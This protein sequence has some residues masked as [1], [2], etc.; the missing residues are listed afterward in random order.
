VITNKFNVELHRTFNYFEEA[1]MKTS[2]RT[3]ILLTF[4]LPLF[5]GCMVY[6][7]AAEFIKQR[8]TNTVA[9]FNTFYN[10]QRAFSDAEDEL[11]KAKKDYDE[12]PNQ[13]KPF[14]ISQ[15]T[16]VKFNASIEKNSKILTFYA[17]SKW[18]DDA[19]FMIGKSYSY[20]EEYAKAERKYLELFAKY[21]EST[22]IPEV[23]LWYGE[24]LLQQKKFDQGT[25]QLEE[26][27]DEKKYDDDIVGKA[28]KDLADYYYTQENYDGALKYDDIALRYISDNEL[29]ASIDYQRG[30][31][32]E[33]MQKYSDAE[34]AF[35]EA[36]DH[37]PGYAMIFRSTMRR[38]GTIEKQKKY[39]DAL[40]IL[41]DLKEDG[42]NAE[43]FGTIHFEIANVLYLK[44]DRTGA[45]DEYNYIDTAYVRTDES[46]KSL[47]RLAQIY[48][49]EYLNYDSAR[50][51]YN[52][53]KIEYPN[54]EITKDALVKANV[55]NK[56]DQL[57]KDLLKYDSLYHKAVIDL[58]SADTMDAWTAMQQSRHPQQEQPSAAVQKQKKIS[59]DSSFIK[60]SRL[61]QKDE[62]SK[63][64]VAAIDST[65]IKIALST[66]TMQKTMIDSMQRTMM[67][68]KF[69]L[70]GLFY[71]ELQQPDSAL[72]WFNDVI[73]YYPK[74][75]LIAQALYTIADIKGTLKTSSNTELDSI[76]TLIINEY[77]KSPYAQESRRI[78]GIPLRTQENDSA[79]VLYEQA[80]L[81]ADNKNYE[82]A[83]TLYK[84]IS[85][86]FSHSPVSP[87]AMYSAGWYYENS[88]SNNDSALAMYRTL[89]TKFPLSQ[90]A[91]AVKPTVMEYD[92]EMKRIEIEKQKKIDEEK[93]KAEDAKRLEEAKAKES[94]PGIPTPESGKGDSLSIHPQQIKEDTL[95][96]RREP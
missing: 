78:L 80:E 22:I 20:M 81:L 42:K 70:A 76:Y 92:N 2:Q 21:P 32:Y 12:K 56:Y 77:P 83:V 61:T 26:L 96:P 86:N 47:Y 59:T 84:K 58:A 57:Q 1:P 8:Y 27:L 45:V 38:I 72:Y 60:E 30:S 10:A 51:Y 82:D 48:E 3:I 75:E 19:L 95:S 39:D 37:A 66:I 35:S 71:I 79:E 23:H 46:A 34:K 4:L 88:L 17:N 5:S 6:T 94:A 52:K 93:K 15:S 36:E 63:D 73:Q 11:L 65:N 16:K 69:E 44:G 89:I 18:V 87:K 85:T 90:Y 43:Y 53:A 62:L 29:V 24:S 9:Y 55:F 74:S 13:G 49:D 31:S 54:S 40:A 67:R 50:V 41:D 25:K 28:A 7:P 91:T 64:S 33:M 68:T 14:T